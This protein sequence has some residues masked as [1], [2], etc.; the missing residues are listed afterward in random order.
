[1]RRSRIATG[2]T[3]LVALVELATGVLLIV[4]PSLFGH[5]LFGVEFRADGTAMARL[6]G[7]ALLALAGACLPVARDPAQAARAL[8]VLLGFSAVSAAYLAYLGARTG[9]WGLL[10]WPAAVGH[11]V[12]A[13]LLVYAWLNGRARP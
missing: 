1:M 2:L 6:G 4:R 12:L 3:T 7:I 11:A 8:R 13:L 10:L 5:L 9:P